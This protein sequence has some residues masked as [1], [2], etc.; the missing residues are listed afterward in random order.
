MVSI[1][2]EILTRRNFSERFKKELVEEY[3]RGHHSVIELGKLYKIQTAIIYRWIY[4]YSLYNKKKLRVVEMAE[5][6]T[7]KVTDLLHQIKDL[8][9]VVG[10]KQLHIDFLEKTVEFADDEF[11]INL[12]KKHIIKQS[13]GTTYIKKN[14]VT[15]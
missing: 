6:S 15:Q 1:K 11:G 2:K 8:E 4:K 3:E 12:K 13:I 14:I 7:K 5:S 10:Q 9:R